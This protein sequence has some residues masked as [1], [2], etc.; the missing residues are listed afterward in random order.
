MKRIVKI[1][2]TILGIV[3][4][5]SL[6]ACGSSAS[7]YDYSYNASTG[8][9]ALYEPDYDY[10]Y[11]EE[12][13]TSNGSNGSMTEAEKVKDNSRKLIKTYNIAVETEE[14]DGFVEMIQN[15][16][17]SLDGYIENLNSSNGSKYSSSYNSSRFSYMTIRI[18]AA[19]ADS[20]LDMVGAN[21]NV[22]SKTLS[23]E[24]VTLS[25]VD[26]QSRKN[27]Y[28]AEEKRLLELLEQAETIEDIL[29]IEDR[30]TNI[31][32]N[33]E[34]LESQLRTYDNKVDYTTIYL[35]ITEVE[36]YTEP[37]P[38]S[39]GQKI[40]KAFTDG[41]DETVN[42]LKNLLLVFVGA[43]P[44]LTVFAIVLLIFVII[45]AVIIRIIYKI[46]TKPSN[47]KKIATAEENADIS[48]TSEE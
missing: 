33:I 24:D 27:A 7:K 28:Q 23:V 30:L 43:I 42:T 36:A 25:Y 3:L 10:G 41:F 45:L 44:G 9:E 21:A 20:F 32:Y 26:V 17:V 29:V 8:T 34:S 48:E 5:M 31:R 46:V 40:S 6:C 12:Y 2:T 22:I 18:P 37:E 16:V 11:S 13:V 15:K 47:K 4:I 38:E 14:F 19:S 35:D 1:T 39:F